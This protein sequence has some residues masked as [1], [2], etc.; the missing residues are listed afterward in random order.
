MSKRGGW[1]LTGVIVVALALCGWFVARPLVIGWL[2]PQ[3]NS[4]ARHYLEQTRVQFGFRRI[5][6]A[7]EGTCRCT[8]TAYYVGPAGVDPVHVFDG[9][10]LTLQPWPP[11]SVGDTRPWD[12]LLTGEG[13]S[14][15]SGYCNVGIDRYQRSS[16]P[17]D[18][19]S[20]SQRERADF[21]AGKLD[22]L[23]LDI[24]CNADGI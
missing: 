16:A 10:G 18:Y 24:G 22:I 9:P 13:N 6:S 17:L 4:G 14:Q 8:L 5:G 23:A 2:D 11:G 20:L 12:F 7:V 1:L 3:H 15:Q 21:Q 19:W